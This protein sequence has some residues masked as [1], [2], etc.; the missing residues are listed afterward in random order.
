MIQAADDVEQW[1]E[2]PGFEG[3]YEVS[4]TGNLRSLDRW[5][6]SG[7]HRKGARLQANRSASGHFKVR[8]CRGGRHHWF[9]VH[10]LVLAAFI[11]PRPEGMQGA[12]NNGDPSDNRPE[13]LRWDTAKGNAADRKS[14]GTEMCGENN[15]RSK[16]TERQVSEIFRMHRS[17]V[18]GKDIAAVMLCTPANISSI[19][20]GKHWRTLCASQ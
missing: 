3:Y 9:G 4:N 20:K 19:L 17:G 13:N 12:H 15:P 2:I 11:G 14:H 18:M 1:R 16:L 5:L 8:L 10:C 7:R 6:T